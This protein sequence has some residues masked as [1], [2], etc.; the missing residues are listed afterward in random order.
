MCM[1]S[2]AYIHVAQYEKWS[3]ILKYESILKD[4]DSFV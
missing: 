4:I 3:Y 2:E 1:G